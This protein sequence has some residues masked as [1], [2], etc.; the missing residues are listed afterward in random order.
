M[1]PVLDKDN[2]PKMLFHMTV[3]DVKLII[4]SRRLAATFS[5]RRNLLGRVGAVLLSYCN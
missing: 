2:E 4:T 5:R 3:N 1:V